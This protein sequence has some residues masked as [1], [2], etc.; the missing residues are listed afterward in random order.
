MLLNFHCKN[1]ILMLMFQQPSEDIPKQVT[2]KYSI[3]QKLLNCTIGIEE[4][5]KIILEGRPT[6]MLFTLLY[7][8]GLTKK[9]SF[10]SYTYDTIYWLA[11]CENARRLYCWPCVLFDGRK[12]KW[13]YKGVNRLSV[14]SDQAKSHKCNSI[15]KSSVQELYAFI[16][17]S[18]IHSEVLN[19]KGHSDEKD[20][21]FS[22]CGID[23]EHVENIIVVNANTHV[24]KS[25]VKFNERCSSLE[26]IGKKKMFQYC[27]VI[28]QS[29]HN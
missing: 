10:R 1:L 24:S 22:K 6:P 28:K 26:I 14:L 7:E 3:I 12:A 21:L 23:P 13:N 18:G 11:G 15:H 5:S 8:I 9:L 16:Y 2:V 17:S 4:K 25:K 29:G 19:I 20:S 27:H